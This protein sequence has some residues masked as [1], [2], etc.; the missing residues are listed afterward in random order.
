MEYRHGK[1]SVY[2]LNYHI[3]FV[4]KY[5]RPCITEEIGDFLKAEII[6]LIESMEGHV[7]EVEYHRD[8]IHILA[9]LSPKHAISEQIG[10]LKGVTAR[11][12]KKRY[13]DQIAQYLWEGQFWAPSFFIAT[14]GGV[15]LDVLKKYVAEQRTG[16]SKGGW[17]DHK[18][19]RHSSP[20]D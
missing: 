1:H 14:A 6:R 9:E 4:T 10:V 11:N 19:N 15:T 8:Y 20:S 5:R 18:K 13:G 7:S 17:H 3:V 2:S 12:V 16:P